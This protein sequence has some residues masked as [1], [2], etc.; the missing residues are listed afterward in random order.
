MSN[1][2][3]ER[4]LGGIGLRLERTQVGDRYVLEAMRAKG[5]NVGGEQ[6]GHIILSDFTT[7]GDGLIAALQLLAVAKLADKPVSEICHRFDKVP[8]LLQS[9]RYKDGKPLEHK[10]VLQVI[11]ESRARLG[12][13][14][15]PRHPRVRHRAGDPRHGRK[16]RRGARCRRRQRDRG[17]HQEGRLTAGAARPRTRLHSSSQVDVKLT[18]TLRLTVATPAFTCC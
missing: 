18:S 16:R 5:F 13:Q 8:Q 2:G 15:A 3:L 1:L 6:T 17:D 9:V 4:Y 14:R 11:S 10:L 12:R 7:T